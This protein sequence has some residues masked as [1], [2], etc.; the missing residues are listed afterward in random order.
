MKRKTIGVVGHGFVGKAVAKGLCHVYDVVVYDKAKG[1]DGYGEKGY[2]PWVYHTEGPREGP[3]AYLVKYCPVIFVCVPTPMRRDGSCDTSIVEGVVGELDKVCCNKWP[4]RSSGMTGPTCIIKSTVPP[5]TTARLQEECGWLELVFNPEFLTEANYIDDFRDQDRIILGG[6]VGAVC[7]VAD[8]YQVAFPRV[9]IYWTGSHTA[10]M[11]K[12][13]TNAFLAVKV[14]FANEVEGLCRK[15]GIEWDEVA[16]L[17][18][19]DDRLGATHWRV[20]GPDGK[21]GF[22]GSCFPKDLNALIQMAKD[23]GLTLNVLRAA[24]FTNLKVRPER[25]WEE[26]KGRAVVEGY[27]EEE[28]G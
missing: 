27:E 24:W 23:K 8:V 25:D 2:R 16:R 15:M 9:N 11:L 3:W 5:G 28:K 4:S 10:E 17:L 1:W 20:P 14:S 7:R 26:L 13:A 19:F 6:E 18:R 12:Y 22:G 21:R